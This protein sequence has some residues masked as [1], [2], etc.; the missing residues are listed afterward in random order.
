M[1]S[2]PD[3]TDLFYSETMLSLHGVY[4]FL[5]GILQR[6]IRQILAILHI[7]DFSTYLA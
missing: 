1:I 2:R 5:S 3:T 6:F 4:P 7:Y